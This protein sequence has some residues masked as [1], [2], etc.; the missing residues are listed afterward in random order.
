MLP[1][2]IANNLKDQNW[3]AIG[4]ELLVLIIGVFL[5]LQ[6]DNWNE[7]RLEQKAVKS[8][9]DRL[10]QNIRTN[11]HNLQTHQDYYQK[12]KTHGEAALSAL[13]T[14]ETKLG[15]QFFIQAYQP[16]QA[17]QM[18]FIRAAY[19]EILSVGAMNNIPAIEARE[20]FANYYN[21]ATGISSDL[22]DANAFR[23]AT[24]AHMPIKVQSSIE[25]NCGD[26]VTVQP[27]GVLNNSLSDDCVPGLDT[28]TIQS[29]IDSLLVAHGIFDK[30]GQKKTNIVIV[31]AALETALT[32]LVVWY[33]WK[34]PR[35]ESDV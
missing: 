5:G 27:N 9:Y 18:V 1:R 30:W 29:A 16:T 15:E 10:I 22:R 21:T 2:R 26:K 6:V 11:E 33:A 7:S 34:W 20:R 32:V 4:V 35:V 28:T 24:R 3:T 13:Q 25:I 12:V 31:C 14:G 17:W 23:E 8:Y 19:D